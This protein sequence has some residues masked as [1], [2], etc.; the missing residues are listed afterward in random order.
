MVPLEVAIEEGGG[1][2]ELVGGSRVDCE[3]VM[4]FVS[5]CWR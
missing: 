5:M 4:E 1:G 2:E 3:P